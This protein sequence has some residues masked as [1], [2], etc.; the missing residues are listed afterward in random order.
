M[1]ATATVKKS[2]AG[3]GGEG[4]PYATIQKGIGVASPGDIVLVHDGAYT[5]S[6]NK[7]LDFKGKN[8]TV[9]SENGAESTIIDCENSG[10]G[11]Y[12]HNGETSDAKVEGFSIQHFPGEVRHISVFENRLEHKMVSLPS[13]RKLPFRWS[14]VRD[15]DHATTEVYFLGNEDER[16]FTIWIE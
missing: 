4:N 7:N 3:D 1:D 15:A 12:F 13:S 8:I 10:R 5:G 11:F 6:G 2:P 9:K 14:N 16:N